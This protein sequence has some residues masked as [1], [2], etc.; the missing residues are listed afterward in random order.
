MS[1]RV[2]YLLYA[3]D[4]ATLVYAGVDTE[5]YEQRRRELEPR[6][7]GSLLGRRRTGRS[8]QW[9]VRCYFRAEP[10]PSFIAH[11]RQSFPYGL[12]WEPSEHAAEAADGA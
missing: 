12:A 3:E 9:V 8:E 2:V 1:E 5:E 7:A 11:R 10:P 4:G 6:Y